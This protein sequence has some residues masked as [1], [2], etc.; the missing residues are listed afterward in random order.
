MSTTA[1]LLSLIFSLAILLIGAVLFTNG[2]EWL[3]EKLHLGQGAVGSLLAAVAT[4]LPETLIP[5]VAVIGGAKGAEQ[6]ATGAIIGAP[7]MLTTLAM[8]VV[9]LAVLGW[10]R[11][12]PQ[13]VGLSVHAPTLARDLAF[14]LTCFGGGFTL[15]LLDAPL[16][17]RLAGA[18]LLVVAY[19]GYVRRTLAHGGEVQAEDSISPLVFDFTKSDPPRLA[20]VIAQ[21]VVALLAIA[22]GADLFVTSLTAVAEDAGVQPL[23]LALVIAPVATELPEQINGV[24]WAR[25]GKDALAFGNITGAMVFQSTIPLAFGLAFTDWNLN[26]TSIVACV[27]TLLGGALTIFEIRVR[28]RI[29]SRGVIAWALLYASF[30]TY[31][32][33]TA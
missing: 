16:W 30:V 10:R 17:L 29:L 8:V 13:G 1:S 22:G 12:R 15:G 25:D 31:V 24:F 28:R 23:V 2:I 18:G 20:A 5:I 7:F 26:D 33:A 9:G 6:V 14:F 19:A 32:L 11:R 27:L 3:G 21:C 4:A